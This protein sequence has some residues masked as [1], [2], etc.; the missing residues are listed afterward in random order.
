MAITIFFIGAI[1]GTLLNLCI[2]T[3][4]Y[5]LS[6]NKSIKI[7]IWVVLV[8]GIIFLA[9]FLKFPQS[10]LMLIKSMIL[11]SLLIV[12]S[13]IDL[14]HRIIPNIV[15][16][17]TLIIGII[18]SFI[19]DISFS[20]SVL[21]MIVG[22]GLLFIFAIIPGA[23]GG[24]DIK[25]MFALGAYLGHI[26][27]LWALILAFIVASIISI[28]LILFKIKSRKDYIPFAPFLALGTFISFLF[29]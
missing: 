6:K 14:K 3:I 21:G 5:K 19:G 27:I 26:K 15:V 23:I 13:F 18:F 20:T 9:A 1:I 12:V 10:N 29:F 24:G 8:T 2:N 22:G 11:G 4:S 16:M 17:I 28:I 25:L 7:N